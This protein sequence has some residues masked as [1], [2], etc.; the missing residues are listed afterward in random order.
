[1]KRK[2]PLAA[3]IAALLLAFLFLVPQRA[4]EG[5]AHLYAVEWNG[6]DVTEKLSPDQRNTLETLAS[7]AQCARWQNSMGAF[8]LREDTVVLSLLSDGMDGPCHF[9]LVGS[10]D[11]YTVTRNGRDYN[12]RDGEAFLYA[13]LDVLKE[14]P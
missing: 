7:D 5:N 13:A 8:P 9:Y 14:T 10:K 2:W 3:G 12:L 1:M 11:R 4:M 6:T